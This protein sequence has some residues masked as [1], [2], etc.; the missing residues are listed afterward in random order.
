[1]NVL[2]L[3][4]PDLTQLDLTGPWE[5]LSRSPELHLD[6]VWK[7]TDPVI[8]NQ[9]LKLLPT[10]S[11]ADA[12][13]ADILFVPGGPG[14][15]PLMD[16]AE[17]L[18]FLRRQAEGARYITSVCTG[19]LVLAAAGLLKGRRA[20]CHWMSLEQLRHFGAEPV[21][22]RVVIDG[23]RIT[24]GGVTSGI[25]FALTLTAELFGEERAQAIQLGM[26]YDPKPPFAGGTPRTAPAGIVAAMRDWA[27][28]FQAARDE[29]ARRAAARLNG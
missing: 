19:S 22:A 28:A 12:P 29:A 6:L 18:A 9:G 7:T 24:G 5:V 27:K 1:M 26:E 4:Y 17:T 16:D 8:A 25:D 11:F 13:Q 3:L 15:L 10:A 2:M 23:N 14:Q 21:E 20:T